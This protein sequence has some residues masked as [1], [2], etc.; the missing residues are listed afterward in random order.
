MVIKGRSRSGPKELAIHL[1]RVDTNERIELLEVRGTTAS[2]LTGALREMDAVA[3]GTRCKRSL[4][5]ASINVPHDE[6]I[7]VERW[8]EAI[9][10]LEAKLGLTG[11]PRVVVMHEKLDREHV[12]VVWSRID[13]SRMAAISD[14]HN[15]RAHEEVARALERE[16]GHRRV[17][18]AH[19]ERGG[20]A[21]PAR[22]ASHADMQRQARSGLKHADITAAVTAMWTSTRTGKEFA[23]AVTAAGHVLARGTRRDVV[24]VDAAGDVHSLARRIVGATAADVSARMSDIRL[25][26]LSDVKTARALQH[27]RSAVENGSPRVIDGRSALSRLLR[28]RSYATEGEIY[29]AAA[30]ERLGAPEAVLAS[31]I[32]DAETVALIEA[33]SGDVIG[34]TT[35]AVR[36]QE[37]ELV[38]RVKRMA[39]SAA[40]ALPNQTIERAVIAARLDAEQ[41]SAVRHACSAGSFAIVLGRAGTGKSITAGVIRQVG[42]QS[43]LEVIGL[44]P[45]N[46]VAEDLRH[47]GFARAGT[48]H[49]L[50]WHL[51]HAPQHANARLTRNSLVVLD[52]A[53]MVDTARLHALTQ[54]IERAGARMVAIGDDRQ[55]GSVERGGMFVDLVRAVG[56]AELSV[57]RRQERHWARAASRAFSEYRF[58]DGL[59]AYGERGLLHWSHALD[60]SRA[61]LVQAWRRDTEAGLG[62]RYVF[63]YTNVET[64]RLNDLLQAIQVERGRVRNLVTLETERGTLRVGEG[65]RI[66]FRGTLKQQGIVNGAQATV[67]AIRDDVLQVRTDRG[68]RIDVD[69]ST[70]TNLDL[71]YAGTIWRGQGKTL[72]ETYLLH[73]RHWRDAASYVALT[74]SK[75]ATHVFVARDQAKD[76]EDLASQMARQTHRGSTLAFEEAKVQAASQNVHHQE[77]ER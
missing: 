14:S 21:R 43:G 62:H 73:T 31:I 2:D 28:T 1:A 4:Y 64:R 67:E 40:P 58:R 50:L 52:E 46:A 48:L 75:G 76:I 63:A 26:A 37:A 39:G 18:G 41:A 20:V 34:F 23:D 25:D 61:V 30:A 72:Q 29:D 54:A 15:Y 66:T 47:A 51:E 69:T 35:K 12:H 57:V 42:E 74:R 3:S 24:L 8:R 59:E 49:S 7:D 11:Q 53:A 44:A 13:V 38:E 5:H 45:T 55:L 56:G 36:R 32:A 16:F 6:R 27:A 10:A 77:Q 9:D 70:F 17:Q 60:A 22:T 19:A 65:D 68:Q 33:G 71:G